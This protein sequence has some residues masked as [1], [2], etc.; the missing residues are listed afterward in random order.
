MGL[1]LG[2]NLGLGLDLVG[3]QLCWAMGRG[4]S[5]LESPNKVQLPQKS[6]PT[7]DQS[8]APT[9]NQKEFDGPMRLCAGSCGHLRWQPY[10]CAC[11]LWEPNCVGR[12]VVDHRCSNRRTKFSSHKKPSQSPI[13][14]QRLQK[15]KRSLI[16]RC[17]CAP[18]HAATYVANHLHVPVPCGSPTV[19]GDGSW[20]IGARIAEQSSA[21][22]KKPSQ[23]PN[24]VQL[25]RKSSQSPY[26]V[27]LPQ[28]KR[29]IAVHRS[30]PTKHQHQEL[31]NRVER[32]QKKRG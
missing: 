20:T 6:R 16:G 1:G 4:P 18:A 26:K 25:P 21:P 14:V 8:S 9:K 15:T 27:Q 28:K 19:L 30:A 12:W 32:L 7:A 5:V 29:Q 22:T 3:A 13:R 23:S 24:R 31:M 11:T 17:G 2:Q 10:A